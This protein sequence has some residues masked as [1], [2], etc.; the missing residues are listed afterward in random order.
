[1]MC[2]AMIFKK[3][4]PGD[5]PSCPVVKNLPADAR[6][7]VL[8][9]GPGRFTCLGATKPVGYN[10]Q[11]CALELLLCNKTATATKS[12]QTTRKSSPT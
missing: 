2:M 4:L 8:I 6:D 12:R 11:T 10:F 1:M 9:S 3:V 5:F 7:T